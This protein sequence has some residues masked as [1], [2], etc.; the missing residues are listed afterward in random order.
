MGH[1]KKN[2][3]NTIVTISTAIFAFVSIVSIFFSVT[4]WWTQR[5]AARPYFTFKESPSIYLTNEL[6]FEFKFCNVGTHPASNLS[7][8]SIVFDKT[9]VQEPMLVDD[10]TVLNDIPR[11]TTTSLLLSI[12]GPDFLPTDI[13]PQF[14]VIYLSYADLVTR[15]IYTQTF[16]TEWAGVIEQKPQALIHVEASQ[17]QNILNYLESHHLATPLP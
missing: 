6:S 8:K 10:Y 2:F 7:S 16:Y 1:E 12:T 17:K 14:L 15:K 11:D 13:N 3:S 5:E 9:L 4:T